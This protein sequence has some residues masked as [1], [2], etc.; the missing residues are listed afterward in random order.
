MNPT[1]VLSIIVA[2]FTILILVSYFTSKNSTNSSFFTADKSSPWFIVAFGMIGA[3]LSGVTFI[4]IPGEVGNSAFSYF[5]IVLGYLLGYFVIAKV[6]L[7][8][9][10]KKNMISIYSFLEERF[11]FLSYKTGAFFFIVSQTIGASFRLFLVAGVLQLG[12]FN[13]IGVPFYATVFITILLIW[14]YTFKSGIK[15]I[16]WT[17]T[18]QTLFML[19]AVI[20]TIFYI[21]SDLNL[22]SGEVVGL[23]TSDNSSDIFVW[24]WKSKHNFFKQFFSGAFI[25]IVMT[26]LDQNMMQKN[27]TC[28]TLAESQKNMFWFSAILVP[29]NFLFLT[30]GLL[31]YTYS[32]SKGIE[33]PKYSD[34][35]FPMLAFDYFPLIVGVTFLIGVIA[36]AFSSADSALTAL[37]TSFCVDFLNFSKKDLNKNKNI[38]IY[39]HIGFSVLMLLV[40][41]L[42]RAINDKS[43]INAVFT[44]AGYTYGPLLGM[45]A[46]G[47]FT[48]INVKDKLVP[49]VAVLSPIL[50]Y[51]INLYSTKLFNGY[52]FGFEL[53][54]LNGMITF[55]GLFLIRKRNTV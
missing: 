36:A 40:I 17:D 11:G 23:L 55:F 15:T 1:I 33:I 22:S 5:Q 32:A 50:C 45:F 3:S 44:V 26:G 4:S 39:T 12:F 42:F 37:T 10:Y 18:L 20:I 27:L 21:I 13:H 29:V 9:Y 43:V 28:R 34:E 41:L 30:M 38:R 35:L 6:L 2:Y 25:A 46:F 52:K 19:L 8:L 24:D 16:V 53:L 31:L 14:I 47:M 7:P 51:I 48:K 49:L 54:I